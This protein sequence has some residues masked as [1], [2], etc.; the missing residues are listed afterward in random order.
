MVNLNCR[1]TKD[2]ESYKVLKYFGI[3]FS[4]ERQVSISMR[5]YAD[6]IMREFSDL[7]RNNIISTLATTKLYDIRGN[8]PNLNPAKKQKFHITVA[9]YLQYLSSS[10]ESQ[11][12]MKM[13]E[14]NSEMLL[15][16]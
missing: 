11:I 12:I 7:L 13:T 3:D 5:H 9:H 2:S 1:K 8:V 15:S 16:T 10:L 6:K 4:V 14:G